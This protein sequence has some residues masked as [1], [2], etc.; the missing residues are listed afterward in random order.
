MCAPTV[1]SMIQ[2]GKRKF[3]MK[4]IHDFSIDYSKIHKVGLLHE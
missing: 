4:H 1:H 2:E 3:V